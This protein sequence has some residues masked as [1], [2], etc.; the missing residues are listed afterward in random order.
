MQPR[1]IHLLS[2]S[3]MISFSSRVPAPPLETPTGTFSALQLGGKRC[4]VL[5]GPGFVE[6]NRSLRRQDKRKWP[7]VVVDSPRYSL[8]KLQ[9][10]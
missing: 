4:G 8:S 3:V 7:W 5:C 1:L 9:I 6:C 2:T 10:D